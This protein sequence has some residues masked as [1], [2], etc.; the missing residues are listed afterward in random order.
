MPTERKICGIR[1]HGPGSAASL[2]E[3]L[4][5]WQ[6]DLVVIE[7]PEDADP[8][9]EQLRKSGVQAF[10]PPVAMLFF[11]P[12]N[13]DRVSFYPFAEYSPEWVALEWAVTQER[14]VAFFDFPYAYTLQLQESP[15]EFTDPQPRS[16]LPPEMQALRSDPIGALAELAGYPDSEQFWDYLVEQ[17]REGE[18]TFSAVNLAMEQLRGAV[19]A[20]G[21]Q[22]SIYDQLRE[23]YMRKRLRTLEKKGFERMLVVCGA[24]HVPALQR[25]VKAKDDN[26]MLKGLRKR[27][28]SASWIPWSDER[29]ANSSGYRAGVRSPAFYRMVWEEGS[30]LATRYMTRAMRILREADFAAAPAQALDAQRLAV[31]LAYLRGMPAPGLQDLQDALHATM[32]YRSDTPF[33]LVKRQLI[34]GERTGALP[35]DFPRPPLQVQVE[36]QMKSLRLKKKDNKTLELDLRKPLDAERSRFF[37]LLRLVDFQWAT[38]EEVEADTL[39]TFREQWKLKWEPELEFQL[40]KLAT[41]GNT[42]PEAVLKTL[43]HFFREEVQDFEK[44]SRLLEDAI[45][46]ELAE[47]VE[48]VLQEL[49]EVSLALNDAGRLA[50]LFPTLVQAARYGNVRSTDR[51][52]LERIGYRIGFRLLGQLGGSLRALEPEAAEEWLSKLKRCHFAYQQLADDNLLRLWMRLI[53]QLA[54]EHATA[55][56]IEGWALR[57]LFDA[58]GEPPNRVRAELR[59]RLE[60]LQNPEEAARWFSGFLGDS[61]AILSQQD[62]LWEIINAWLMSV[63]ANDFKEFVPFLRR[64]FSRFNP[65]QRQDLAGTIKRRLAAEDL[66][67][68]EPAS[69]EEKTPDT[70]QLPAAYR[71]FLVAT[72]TGQRPH[73]PE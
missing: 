11:D 73:P 30:Q 40:I 6:P 50:L 66:P 7:G 5:D 12:K 53:R 59:S 26:A 16:E 27:K 68:P 38:E 69:P 43:E 67:E 49:D 72:L 23:A 46:S 33:Q 25:T 20:A 15:D 14:P 17:R 54:F 47:A 45:K 41:Y 63:S 9:V 36:R 34:I 70:A 51:S 18:K 28:I 31:N 8:L 61:L 62:G 29:L 48:Y 19:E 60:R 24:W 37:H 52:L 35:E 1:H 44:L 10:V 42:L 32:G 71:A 13:P 65:V 57:L 55:P 56:E 21:F 2:L 4:E 39:G 64:A 3:T 58:P 22:L